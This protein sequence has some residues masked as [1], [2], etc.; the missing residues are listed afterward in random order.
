MMGSMGNFS[1]MKNIER[2]ELAQGVFLDL[3]ST[4]KIT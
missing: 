4:G 3:F 1:P 2:I